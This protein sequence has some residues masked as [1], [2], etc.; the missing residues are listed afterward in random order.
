MNNLKNIQHLNISGMTCT[1]CAKGIEKHLTNKG[2]KDVKVDFSSSSVQFI[3][4][5]NQNIKNVINDIKSIGFNAHEHSIEDDNRLEKFFTISLIFTIPLFCH[6]FVNDQHILRNPIIQLFLTLPVYAIGCYYFGKSAWA[7]LKVKTPNMDVLI[8]MG[9]TAAFFYS[10]IGMILFWHTS[11]LHDYLFFE[12]TATIITLVLLGNVLE[13]RSVKQTTTAIKDL[14]AIQNLKGKLV[15]KNGK[16][17]EVLFEDIQV[18]D[19]LLVNTGDKIPTDSKI[20]SGEGFVNESMISGESNPILKKEGDSVIGGTIL[21]NGNLKIIAQK[22]GKETILSSIIKMV[23]DAQGS[24]PNIERLGDKISSIFVPVVLLISLITFL[25]NNLVFDISTTDSILRSVAVLV[26]SCPCAMGLAT[27]TAIMVGIGR[28][29]KMGILIKGGTTLEEF[30]KVKSI[31]F[32]KTGTITTGNFNIKEVDCKKENKKT[33]YDI[34]Y[35]LELHS[36]HPIAKSFV[37]Y[38]RALGQQIELE[39]IKE[40][41]GLGIQAEWKND[42]YRLGS[43]K[44]VNHHDDKYQIFLKKNDTII[45]RINCEDEVKEFSNETIKRLKSDHLSCILLSGDK[46]KICKEVADK[47]GISEVFYEQ[48]PD[49]KLQKIEMI[50][51]N[52]PTAM[53]G[54]GIND[55]PALAKANIGISIGGSTQI[56]IDTAQIVL[57]NKN[58]LKQVH[59]AYRISKH[60]LITIKQNLFWAFS[61][62][63]VAIP[64]AAVGLLNPMWGALFM[65]FSDVIVIGNSIRLKR[66]RIFK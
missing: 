32:D 4:Q 28:A 60:T 63:L 30:A 17:E 23:K 52:G 11:E 19:V 22:V 18:K 62:N 38:F 20:L 3:L 9:S 51:S 48:L 44:F 59:Q 61:Y 6:M 2:F 36:S 40:F 42:I 12:T 56:A 64:I 53:I 8:M 26:I 7:S 21:L 34:I 24:K 33:I 47:I 65:A 55:A 15:N 29:A 37:N 27:P 49:E 10:L 35:S 43:T 25:I 41:K 54:D 13:H 50:N 46:S 5:D 14:S 31:V 66:K 57:L 45:A 1:N 39:N 58:H 16:I